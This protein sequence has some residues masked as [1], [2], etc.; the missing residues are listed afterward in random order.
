MS[1]PYHIVM[2]LTEKEQIVPK[3]E[4]VVQKKK[5]SQKNLKKQKLMAQEQ[6]KHKINAN[7]SEKK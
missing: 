6:I 3:L 4:E 1:S 5:T 7:K 2:I